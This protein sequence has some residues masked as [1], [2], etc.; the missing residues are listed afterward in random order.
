MSSCRWSGGSMRRTKTSPMLSKPR[1]ISSNRK[2]KALQLVY[3]ASLKFLI[4][5][6]NEKPLAPFED[7]GF[8]NISTTCKR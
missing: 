8:K 4:L 7:F 3:K 6:N 5:S 2:M 1:S